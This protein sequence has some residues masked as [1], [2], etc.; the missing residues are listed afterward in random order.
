M[1]KRS[2]RARKQTAARPQQTQSNQSTTATV[3][4]ATPKS[5]TS[6]PTPAVAASVSGKSVDFGAEYYYVYTEL[7][8]ITFV[9][10]AMFAFM[11]GL[12]FF[13]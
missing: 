3:E 1:A 8:N 4:E 2:R 12:G 6:Q 10:L 11:V 5:V 7:R 9:A 13:I